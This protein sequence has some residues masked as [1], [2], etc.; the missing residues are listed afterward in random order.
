MERSDTVS[1]TNLG[2]V[3]YCKAQLGRPY[4]MGTFGNIA[5][6]ALYRANKRRLPAYYTANDFPSQYGKRVHD[7]IGLVKGYIWSNGPDEAPQ[8]Q[9]NGC[10]DINEA[11]MYNI[12]TEKGNIAALPEIPGV[13]VFMPGHVGVYIGNGEVIEAR[14]HAYGVVKT[15]LVN[16]QWTQWAKCPYIE[17]EEDYMTDQEVYEAVI[18]YSESLELPTNWD[19]K[20]ELDE[21]IALGITDGTRP[22]QLIP[23]YQAAIMAAR[24]VKKALEG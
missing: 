20:A 19:A 15:K 23:R 5:T 17:Y 12:A 2:L 13:L 14:G 3:E 9:S 10:P 7:C 6:A 11:Q 16:R 21:A 8:Y 22:M 18:R 24:A 1:K 4:W